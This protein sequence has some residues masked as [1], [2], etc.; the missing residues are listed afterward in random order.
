[1]PWSGT[2]DN[3]DTATTWRRGLDAAGRPHGHGVVAYSA[4]DLW[5]LEEG[6]MAAGR[7]QGEWVSRRRDGRWSADLREDDILRREGPSRERAGQGREE[8][9]QG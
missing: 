3:F 7:R 4:G 2:D 9:G 5:E 6:A 1:M 8:R